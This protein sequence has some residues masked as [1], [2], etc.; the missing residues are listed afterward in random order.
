MSTFPTLRAG[1]LVALTLNAAVTLAGPQSGHAVFVM[2]NDAEKNEVVSFART[3]DG[4]L[5][6]PRSYKTEGRGSGGK[7]DPLASQGSLTMSPDGNWLLAANA[8]SGTISAFAVDG[9]R[10]YFTDTITS[11]GSE[12][13]S[14]AQHGRLVYVLNAAGA[15]S[16]VGFNFEGGRFYKIRDSIRYLSGTAVG[17][18]SVAFSADGHW[19]AVTEK[20]TTSIDIFKVYG[21]GTLS[22]P[23]IN[24]NVGPGTFSAVFAANGTLLVA[25]TGVSGAV[26]AAA[27][28]SYAVQ[29]DGTLKAISASLP[30]LASATC[31]DAVS[32]RRFYTSNA[33][34]ANLSGFSIE[35]NGSLVPL[36]GTAVG[37]NP[38]GSTNIDV[39]ASLDGRFVYTLNA[40]TGTIGQFAVQEPNG[41]LKSLGVA[42]QLPAASG[43]NGIAAN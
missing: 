30:S 31:W 17:P 37:S 12:P 42:G 11:G 3:Q 10:L 16:V 4:S 27:V 9:S 33:G 8:G 36:S 35:S 28:S 43:F 38:A 14:I 32:G 7:V 29:S 15:S 5:E 1:A 6:D 26:N 40:A 22:P 41:E 13:N 18:G 19:L 39:A 21:D 20:A 24:K 23:T 34:S 2:T 25:E